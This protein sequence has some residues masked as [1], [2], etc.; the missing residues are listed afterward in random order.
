MKISIILPLFDRRNAGWGSL[1]SA[2]SQ[3]FPR[4]GYEVIAVTGR[5]QGADIDGDAVAALI[6][7]CD[8]VVRTEVDTE[9]V[10]SEIQLYQAGYERAT[11]DVLLFMEGHTVLEKNCCA[12]IDAYFGRHPESV[13][14][15]APRINHG[16]SR[17]GAL[18]TMHN[19]RHERRA[20]EKGVFSLGANSVIKR[21]LFDRLGGFDA[22]YMRFSETAV[23]HRALKEQ[24]EIGRIGEP[25][26]THYNDMP[27]GWWRELVMKTGEAK[28]SYYNSLHARGEDVRTQVRHRVYLH[29]NHVWSARLLYPLCRVAGALF[30]GLALGT[31]RISKAIA[32]HLYVLGVGFTDLSGFCRARIRAAKPQQF[33]R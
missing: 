33:A 7:R 9:D 15:W 4:T 31:L 12:V 20:V 2:I 3:E 6:S 25:L 27:V 23:L 19:L 5:G 32:S 17:L 21:S 13:I 18:I 29:A 11:G 28:F 1:E 22:R 16:E 10:S 24:V 26:A 8:T 30:L 14:A